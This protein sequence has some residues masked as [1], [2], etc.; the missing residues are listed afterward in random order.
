MPSHPEAQTRPL[1]ASERSW[2]MPYLAR[3]PKEFDP[4]A[5]QP[6]P[7]TWMTIAIWA[8]ILVGVL[9]NVLYVIKLVFWSFELDAKA[10]VP[11]FL[12]P[13]IDSLVL[14]VMCV[15]LFLWLHKIANRLLAKPSPPLHIDPSVGPIAYRT[16][17]LCTGA[18]RMPRFRG[19]PCILP[20]GWL[21]GFPEGL[22]T[23]EVVPGFHPPS[24]QWYWVAVGMGETDRLETEIARGL[25]EYHPD[26]IRSRMET[27]LSFAAALVLVAFS[28]SKWGFQSW[29]NFLRREFAALVLRAESDLD[30]V[31]LDPGREIVLE[32]PHVLS[33]NRVA[34]GQE[35]GLVPV[36]LEPGPQARDRHRQVV[37]SIL[38]RIEARETWLGEDAEYRSEQL[39]RRLL[40]G[41]DASLAGNRRWDEIQAKLDQVARENP[42][43]PAAYRERWRSEIAEKAVSAEGIAVMRTWETPVLEG[44]ARSAFAALEDGSRPFWI[45]GK[46]PRPWPSGLSI[47]PNDS[48]IQAL[49]KIRTMNARSPTL[50]AIV[51]RHSSSGWI[52]DSGS[53][54]PSLS[55][56]LVGWLFLAAV[57]IPWT[58]AMTILQHRRNRRYLAASEQWFTTGASA[59]GSQPLPPPDGTP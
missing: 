15:P 9:A 22:A 29:D 27:L 17:G 40:Q 8:V 11:W 5:S 57:L 38:R 12:E 36:I 54:A 19:I 6:I 23:L 59:P 3:D 30:Q 26:R 42:E 55:V 45:R 18:S 16:E 4:E 2:V 50:H 39:T 35:A 10:S 44:L 48:R 49:E 1:T 37:D 25:L 7:W 14:I 51:S 52:A 43:A 41:P 24:N 32:T 31:Q 21:S 28:G 47:H 46:K 53:R 13:G 56:F 33:G 34:P 58:I 20:P